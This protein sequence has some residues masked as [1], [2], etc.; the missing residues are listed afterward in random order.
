MVTFPAFAFLGG[1]VP[2]GGLA[3]FF[4][5]G[6]VAAVNPC[7]F[8][9]LPAY[10][11]YFLGLEDDR[12]VERGSVAAGLVATKARAGLAQLSTIALAMRVGFV[13]SAGFMTVF[14]LAGLAISH[15]PLPVF[16][17]APWISIVIGLA[18]VVLGVAMVRGFELTVNLPKLDR[19]G[20]ERT[21]VSMYLFGLSY[22]IASIGCTL[23]LFLINVT[24]AMN[25]DSVADG[26]VVF[27]LYAAGMAFVLMAL[28]VTMAMARTTLVSALRSARAYVNVVAGVLVALAGAYVALYWALALRTF[29]AGEAGDLPSSGLTGPLTD[30]SFDVSGWIESTGIFGFTL[31]F[32]VLLAVLGFVGVSV[33]RLTRSSSP[34]PR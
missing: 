11:S 5:L 27:A 15:T 17:Y 3:F 13:V 1:L 28:T 6:M 9:M 25:R 2:T 12:P 18:M 33:R 19:G 31:W 21:L 4:T 26:V 10:L 8:A 29:N 32:G 7:G 16:E 34:S 20:S 22:A 30:L 24:G 14:G 23:P